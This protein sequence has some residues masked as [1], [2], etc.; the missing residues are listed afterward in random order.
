MAF[1]PA[2]LRLMPLTVTVKRANVPPTYDGYGN[3][4]LS[5][6][7]KTY[8]GSRQPASGDERVATREGEVVSVSMKIFLDCQDHLT[9]DDEVTLPDGINPQNKPLLAVKYWDDGN[10]PHHTVLL[11]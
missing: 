2:Y 10:G 4:I 11:Y 6:N 9:I 1:N 5:S 7:T 8:R 3:P